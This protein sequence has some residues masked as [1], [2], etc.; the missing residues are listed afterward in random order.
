MNETP[1]AP[2]YYEE[3]DAVI[4]HAGVPVER[5]VFMRWLEMAA[6]DVGAVMR[7]YDEQGRT[8]RLRR[9]ARHPLGIE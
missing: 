9:R 5:A 8:M 1:R 6:V 4:T 7:R 3:Y 2:A